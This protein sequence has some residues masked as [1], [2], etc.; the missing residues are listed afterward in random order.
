MCTN[1]REVFVEFPGGKP[2]SMQ[3]VANGSSTVTTIF[4]GVD[5]IRVGVNDVGDGPE[6]AAGASDEG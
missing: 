2:V 3:V 6:T 1:R 5:E 4:L